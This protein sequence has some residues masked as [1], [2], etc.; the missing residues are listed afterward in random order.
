[1]QRCLE[2]PAK[3]AVI[4]IPALGGYVS[5]TRLTMLEHVARLLD[6]CLH[7]YLLGR[8]LKNLTG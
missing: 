2:L 8:Q 3:C 5:N 7:Q 4:R 6:P 1:M